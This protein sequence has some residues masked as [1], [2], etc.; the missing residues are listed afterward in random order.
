ML[1]RDQFTIELRRDQ[2]VVVETIGEANVRLIAVVARK[3]NMLH[4][5]FWSNEIDE[6]EKRHAT[7]S[8][9]RTC[10]RW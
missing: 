8:G 6:G 7:A 5:A 9:N 3:E 2:D 1:S 10:S 4:L